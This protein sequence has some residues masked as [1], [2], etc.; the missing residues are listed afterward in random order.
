MSTPTTNFGWI[1]PTLFGNINTWG[2]PLNTNLDSQDSLIRRFMNNFI[3][4]TAPT[5]AQA[6][7]TWLDNATNPFVLKIYDGTDWITMGTLNT[8]T[9]TFIP[10]TT[11]AVGDYKYSAIAT[12]HGGWLLC[13]G[14]NVSTTT[15]SGLLN[16]ISTAFGASP[17]AGTFYLP[18]ARGGIVGATGQRTGTSS[19]S[20]GN[21]PEPIEETHLMTINEMPSHTHATRSTFSSSFG[22]SETRANN[23]G[24]GNS[25]QADDSW[26]RPTKATGGDARFNIMQPTLFI[27]NL[28]IYAGV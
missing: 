19:W 1:K 20:M 21:K 10:Y 22:L 25:Q 15:Y 27:G 5:E 13:D 9:N 11:V 8:T 12:D 14:R 17:P 24:A 23:F 7:T 6:G 4:A 3:G 26:A 16:A 2:S 18:D 28:F